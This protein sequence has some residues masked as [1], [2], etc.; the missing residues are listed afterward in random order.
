MGTLLGRAHQSIRLRCYPILGLFIGQQT[1]WFCNVRV[2]IR[3]S[4]AVHA[5][6]AA[7]SYTQARKTIHRELFF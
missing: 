4:A 1:Y 7:Y 2:L 3:I 5:Y 6:D